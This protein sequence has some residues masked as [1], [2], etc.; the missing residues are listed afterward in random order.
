MATPVNW[1]QGED[2]II[3]PA[4]DD[5]AAKARRAGRRLNPIFASFINRAEKRP[6]ELR[7]IKHGNTPSPVAILHHGGRVG[8]LYVLLNKS[9]YPF[10]F[11]IE[12]R[13]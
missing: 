2:V 11:L 7:T 6:P 9:L 10:K 5:R 3:V 8:T 1:Q 4:L 12:F 13:L